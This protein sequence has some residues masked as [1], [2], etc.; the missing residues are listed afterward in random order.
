MQAVVLAGGLATRNASARSHDSEVD[1]GGLWRG[2]RRLA[3]RKARGVRLRRRR[4]VHRSPRRTN[5][6][7]RGDGASRCARSVAAE[8]ARLLGTADAMRAA[9]AMLATTFLVTYG[10][11]YLPFD[12]ASPRRTE[13]SARTHIVWRSKRSDRPRSRRGVRSPIFRGASAFLWAGCDRSSAR[14]GAQPR[15]ALRTQGLAHTGCSE[16]AFL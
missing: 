11:S 16:R 7:S 4:H 12:D 5:P 14:T 15:P 3:A 8:G 2:F 9:L 1:A 6:P 10:D 13:R